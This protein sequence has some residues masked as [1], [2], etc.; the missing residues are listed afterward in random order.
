MLTR[1]DKHGE[2]TA[3]NLELLAGEEERTGLSGKQA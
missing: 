1:A 2:G 3:A